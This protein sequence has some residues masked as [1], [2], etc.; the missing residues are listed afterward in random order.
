MDPKPEPKHTPE[1]WV[2]QT[3]HGDHY[4]LG[5]NNR[6][7]AFFE[8]D[9]ATGIDDAAPNAQRTVACVNACAGM[10]SPE[11]EIRTLKADSGYLRK[12]RDAYCELVSRQQKLASACEKALGD[13]TDDAF[14]EL[15][16]ALDRFRPTPPEER[17]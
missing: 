15:R 9:D 3:A 14:S 2:A 10:E 6:F 4:I 5:A 12:Y 17:A 1:P 7:V 13:W 11:H 8:S 16:A